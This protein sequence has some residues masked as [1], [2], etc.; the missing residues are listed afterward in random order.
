MLF[1]YTAIRRATVVLLPL[2][3]AVGALAL[4]ATPAAAT[5]PDPLDAIGSEFREAMVAPVRAQ[6]DR[7]VALRLAESVEGI[8]PVSHPVAAPDPGVTARADGG[9]S[10]R[11][12]LSVARPASSRL[13][14]TVGP[15]N[16][17]DCQFVPTP[18]PIA[19]GMR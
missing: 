4:G 8:R 18:K 11:L 5:P 12:T 17:V 9:R 19:Q 16:E 14:C 15:D 7:L 2:L 3:A 6:L 10:A 13:A 1:R